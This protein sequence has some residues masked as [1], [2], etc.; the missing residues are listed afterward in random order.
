MKYVSLY[1]KFR[2]YG[3]DE[4]VGQDHIVRTL[5]SQIKN[6][7]LSHAYLFCGPRGTGKTSTALVLARAANCLSPVNGDACGECEYCRKIKNHEN[8]D[9]VE[10]D[11]ASNNGVDEI[12]DLRERIRYMPA[13]GNYK[14]YIIDEVHMLS[15]AAAN[16]LLKTLEEPPEYVIFI[17]ATTEPHKLLSTII[18]RCQKFDF[19]A[20]TPDVVEKRLKYVAQQ[21][22]ID[23]DDDALSLIA[24][25]ADGGMRNALGLL[26]Q[27]S[28]YAHGRITAQDVSDVIGAASDQFM[29]SF[30][31]ALGKGDA[32]AILRYLD[33]FISQ[34][35][36]IGVF[37]VELSHCLRDMLMI[38]L[39]G[40]EEREYSVTRAEFYKSAVDL[41]SG[42]M[43]M[44][45]IEALARLEGDLKY[46]AQ[47]RVLTEVTLVRICRSDVRDNIDILAERVDKLSA[48]VDEIFEN[49]VTVNKK[50]SSKAQEHSESAIKKEQPAP[51]E[52]KK[53]EE[54]PVSAPKAADTAPSQESQGGMPA[55][56]AWNVLMAEYKKSNSAFLAQ[57]KQGK[58]SIINENEINLLFDSGAKMF[59]NLLKKKNS[60]KEIEDR[61]TAITGR[62]MKFA[63]V[64]AIEHQNED[65]SVL[66]MAQKVKDILGGV[67]IEII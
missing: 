10:I 63:I 30:I 57:L 51:A 54:R 12:R 66:E 13:L 16:A 46:S 59:A 22:S 2:P 64:T 35:R 47:P 56:E 62:A 6:G 5:R 32:P 15:V 40:L 1:R 28:D 67:E 21:A 9:I 65:N 33:E 31:R 23:V 25:W 19:R 4:V 38:R 14:V 45:A 39:S 8:A 48:R 60:D 41:F 52:E 43:L 29:F 11:A 36:D 3:F 17:L 20:I 50:A 24:R 49:G 53:E 55:R 26:D 37:I 44:Y 42:N 7:R 61:L 34:G 18:S 27:S 58:V